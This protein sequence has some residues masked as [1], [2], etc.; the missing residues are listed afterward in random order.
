MAHDHRMNPVGSN[1][2]A[3]PLITAIAKRVGRRN[4]PDSRLMRETLINKIA[5]YR[6]TAYEVNNAYGGP[7][8]GGWYYSE[9]TP[10]AHSRP[11]LTAGGA[12]KSAERMSEE[13]PKTGSRGSVRN[14]SSS[15][16]Y[17]ADRDSGADM[18]DYESGREHT[19]SGYNPAYDPDS[20]YEVTIGRGKGK[21]YPKTRPYYE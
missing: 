12:R 19:S 6:A 1:H 17:D 8:E 11:H 5:P 2:I 9:G 10:V 18:Y 4:D 3:T 20:D 13:F 14:M 15:D 7:E 21:S 16:M